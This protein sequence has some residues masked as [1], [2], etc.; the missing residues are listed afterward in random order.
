MYAYTYYFAHEPFTLFTLRW[1]GDFGHCSLFVI[2]SEAKDLVYIQEANNVV[3]AHEILRRKA[4]LNDTVKKIWMT[5][6][7]MV[8]G[9]KG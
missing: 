8:K 9:V 4:P 7:C 1:N 2:L 3:D 5:M 6:I